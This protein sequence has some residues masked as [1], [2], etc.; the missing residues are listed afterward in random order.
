VF[1][2]TNAKQVADLRR[3]IDLADRERASAEQYL[4]RSEVQQIQAQSEF[5]NSMILRKSFSWTDAF[6]ELE[7]VMPQR[8]HV[9]SIAPE[10]NDEGHLELRLAVSGPI[11]GAAIELAR[12]LDQSPRF[13]QARIL[14]ERTESNNA[15][16]YTVTA[17]YVP[18]SARTPERQNPA[19]VGGRAQHTAFADRGRGMEAANVRR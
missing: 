8:L 11:R 5:L 1:W 10:I 17:I 3:Q 4:N 6:M 15:V 14:D 9:N 2:Y 16:D 12:R 18:L 19:S 13:L 7:Q